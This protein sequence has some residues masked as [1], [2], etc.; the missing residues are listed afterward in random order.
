MVKKDKEIVGFHSILFVVFV[1][2]LMSSLEFRFDQE[3]TFCISQ[4]DTQVGEERWAKMLARSRAI[5]LP[6]TRWRASGGVP[7]YSFAG[8][9]NPGQIG[10]AQSHISIWKKIVDS[11]LDYA[12]IL[13]DDAMFD[14]KWRTRL[15]WLPWQVQDGE[16]DAIFLNVSE[17]CVPK[18]KW[19]KAEEQYL[20]GGY[21][22]S[23]RGAANVLSMFDGCFFSSDWM[24]RCLQ[25][26]GHSYTYFPWLIIQEGKES[27]IG[28]GFVDDHLKVVRC[29]DEIN[30]ALDS[31]V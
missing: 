4:Y 3:N 10:C 23:R 27:T 31:Y 29:L 20:T 19:V 9:L 17:P 5:N 16:W 11:G 1:H 28:S 26:R 24:T 6:M 2:S 22:I 18:H 25:T 7:I 8:G 21:I 30:Y 12:L 15:A 13:E 14:R